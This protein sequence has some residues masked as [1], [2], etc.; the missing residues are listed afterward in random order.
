MEEKLFS[1]QGSLLTRGPSTY[2]IPGFKDIPEVFNVTLLQN[3]PNPLAIHSSKAVG[4]PPLFLGVSV[5][6]AIKDAVA[7]ARSRQCRMTFKFLF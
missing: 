3:A 1:P 6:F 2:K 4:E 5:Y 7:A